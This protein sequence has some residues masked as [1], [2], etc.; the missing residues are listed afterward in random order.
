MGYIC[1]ACGE[2]LPEDEECPCMA[3]GDDEL[4]DVRGHPQERRRKFPVAE[5]IKIGERDN[6]LC[7]ICQDPARPVERP[8][9]RLGRGITI[10][11]AEVV[12]PGEES[13]DESP[14]PAERCPPRPLSA[15]IDHIVPLAT[16]GTDDP[17]NLQLAHLFC[18]LHKNASSSGAGFMRP[19]YVRAV[20]LIDGI[21]VPE[22]IHR[23]CFPSWAYPA[24]RRV[25]FM[26]AL[27]IAAGDLAADP[28]YGDPA[29]R[30]DRFIR[31]LGDDRW[32][33]AVGD[34]KERRAKWRARWGV[35]HL[36]A[37]M[38]HQAGVAT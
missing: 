22:E 4:E 30:S 12:P 8:P 14:E 38:P 31:E 9:V 34:M 10:L 24:S 36:R 1:P 25:E 15:S 35:V 28:R 7:G 16:D 11:A 33:E 27:C 20:T 17:G 6:R 32:Q 5:R 3:A 19:E 29:L 23:S 2:G 37:E 21:P 13:L 18:N 26:I